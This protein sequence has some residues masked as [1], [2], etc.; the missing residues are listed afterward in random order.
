MSYSGAEALGELLAIAEAKTRERG[1]R[2]TVPEIFSAPMSQE[3][4]ARLEE[5]VE[6][7]TGGPD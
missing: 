2:P 3:E 4:R 7:A 6:R 5:L 1:R